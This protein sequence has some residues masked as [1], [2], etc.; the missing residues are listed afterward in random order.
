MEKKEL[1]SEELG[2]KKAISY[3]SGRGN[4]RMPENQASVNNVISKGKKTSY[5]SIYFGDWA[6]LVNYSLVSIASKEDK[7]YLAFHCDKLVKDSFIIRHEKNNKGSHNTKIYNKTCVHFI[8]DF[9][10]KDKS[11]NDNF[12]IILQKYTEKKGLIVYIID[13][14]ENLEKKSIFETFGI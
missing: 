7:C 3:G 12:K 11:V 8:M 5:Y 1:F 14:K 4:N 2:F 13:K 6:D 10:G 9:L